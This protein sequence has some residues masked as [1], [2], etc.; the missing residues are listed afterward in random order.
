MLNKKS[1][2]EAIVESL[3]GI[4]LPEVDFEKYYRSHEEDNQKIKPLVEFYEQI[5]DFV[6]NGHV[7]TGAKLPFARTHNRFRFRGGE[8]TLWTG[9]NGHKKSMLLGY[10]ANQF[11]KDGEKVCIASF[12]MKPISTIERMTRQQTGCEKA[13]YDEF[14]D[15]LAFAGNNLYLFDQ[16]GGLSPERLLGVIY[17]CAEEL[18]IK[19]FIID[20][21]MRVIAGEDKYNEQK[22]FVVKLC[23]VAIKTNIHIHLVHHT[24]K[25]KESEPSGRYDAKGSGAISDN[26]HNSLI[27]WSNKEKKEGIPDVIL[28]C[29][30]Q[31]QGSWEG[32]IPLDFC[33]TT[34]QFTES[35][36]HGTAD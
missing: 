27:V 31:R 28:K 19:H 36:K 20:S 35:Y 23:E 13:G 17:Y 2:L 15:Y 33:E 8:V 24:K 6:E 32:S 9:Y 1:R 26:V 34:M 21:L 25:G 14:S 18:K 7:I 10:A 30:K 29:D 5:E 22:D 16:Q 4:V 11:L 3:D 12:E